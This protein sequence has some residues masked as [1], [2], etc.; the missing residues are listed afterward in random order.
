MDIPAADWSAAIPARHSR[1]LY[2]SRP[3]TGAELAGLEMVVN[4]FRPFPEARCVLLPSSPDAIFR[5]IA[6]SYGSIKGAA[7]AVF[8]G[9]M[10]SPYVQE[11]VGGLSFLGGSA[12]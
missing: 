8:L 1:R 12:C 10:T 3:L 4:E 2:D 6:G 5:G 9:D 7:A 11:R